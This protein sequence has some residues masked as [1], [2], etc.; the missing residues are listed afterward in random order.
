MKIYIYYSEWCYVKQ[1]KLYL[2]EGRGYFAKMDEIDYAFS[3]LK[4]FI[5]YCWP[6]KI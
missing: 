5:L 2:G 4:G 1:E 6:I 3:C